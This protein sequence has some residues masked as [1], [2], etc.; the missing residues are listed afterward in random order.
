MKKLT[1]GILAHV[2][3]G[4]TTLSEAL[5]YISGNIRKLGRVD[6]ADAF[7]DTY[8]LERQR[9]IT[10]FSKQAMLRG[11]DYEYTLL[12]TPGHVDFSPETERTLAVLDVAILVIS[13]IDG[14]QSHTETLWRLLRK[15]NVPVFIFIN[16]M[17]IPSADSETLMSGIRKKLSVS[18]IESDKLSDWEETAMCDEELMEKYLADGVLSEADISA[19]IGKAKLFPCFFGSALKTDGVKELLDGIKKYMPEPYRNERFG[20]RIYKITHDDSGKRIVHMKIT[21]GN[22]SAKDQLCGKTRDGMEW[23]EKV[24]EI[25]IYSGTKYESV[26]TV[27]AGTVCAV[28]GLESA[29]SG[30]TLGFEEELS[31]PVLEPVFN[32][33]MILPEKEDPF[34]VYRKL[35]TLEEEEPQLRISYDDRKKEIKL[36][37]M[38][39][40][41]LEI[42]RYVIEQRY[43]ISVDFDAGSV[44]YR[45]TV[46]DIAEGVG[47]YEPLRHYAE[48]HLIIEP[49]ER[50]SGLSFCTDCSTDK[51]ERSWQRLILTHL[52]EKV[53]LGVL[54]GSPITD[55]KI[56]LVAGRAHK[57]HTE[58]GDFREAT[59]RAVRHG[60]RRAK[61]VLLEPY[62]NYRI[63]VPD[64]SVGRVM[65]DMQR[66]GAVIN[67]P[68]SDGE[69]SV[70]TGIAPVSEIQ[71]YGHTLADFSH[72]KG[73]ISF[74]LKGYEECHNSEE[75]IEAI[76]YDADADKENP[77]DSVFCAHGAGFLVKWNEVENYMHIERVL[78]R[79]A[80]AEEAKKELKARAERY[81]AN[82]A[83][84][85]EL[86]EIFVRTYGPIRR[87]DSGK[88]K[89]E[90]KNADQAEN[91]KQKQRPK[92]MPVFDGEE[93]LLVDGYNIIFAWDE[94]AAEAKKSLDLARNSLIHRLCNYQGF[95]GIN[96]ILVF[97]AYKV[98]KNPGTV[99]SYRNIDVVYTKEAETADAYIERVSHELSKK[100][101]V[102]VATSDGPEQLII[103]GNGALRVP[104]AAFHKEVSEAEKAIRSMIEI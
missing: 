87:R 30:D 49:S 33:K 73:S 16:K 24:D 57:K 3:S 4:K 67:Q 37:L 81:L 35:K 27:F 29:M 12:D 89:H 69:M 95:S 25:R 14:V 76:G 55:M 44:I 31:L 39:Q 63:S 52:E 11:E 78:G 19:A 7:L 91:A 104:A 50:G 21:G 66:I 75:V 8:Q 20:A 82:V 85:K 100:H 53:H 41:Q 32:Y 94:L 45:E 90:V 40:V 1:V 97:D 10:I 6:H 98:K 93:Y 88:I 74:T 48:V 79:S 54:T 56:T 46:A 43:G 68:E 26:K 86:M 80:E 9:G 58:G 47:H 77:C 15:H 36:L 2:D 38:G 84:D 92:K 99:E 101:R 103:L 51:L 18:C 70:V 71:H 65:A 83:D 102:R 28:T 23:Q 60:L 62:Y 96:I 64:T 42:I 34:V 59:Y 13:G 72:G 5:L 22:L 61:S 17:D